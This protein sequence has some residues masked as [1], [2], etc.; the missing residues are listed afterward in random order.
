[1]AQATLTR[2]A[3]STG[4]DSSAREV[5]VAGALAGALGG[6]VM[7]VALIID[8]VLHG[9]SP[10]ARLQLLG[11]P[12]PG[13]G[14]D[15]PAGVVVHLLVSAA[16]GVPFAAFVPRD[17]PTGAAMVMGIGYAFAVLALMTSCVYPAANPVLDEHLPSMGG[18]W[19]IARALFGAVTGLAPWFRR[20]LR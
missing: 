14:V 18:A 19:V 11:A 16:L 7:L 17:F 6:A 9:S 3:P 15:V 1:M 5:L 12:F 2:Q 8:A 10:W 4:E 13:S 20:R